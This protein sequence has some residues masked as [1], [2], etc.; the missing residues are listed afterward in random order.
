MRDVLGR[1]DCSSATS[2][3]VEHAAA[4]AH[5]K[6][7]V[8]V[9]VSTAVKGVIASTTGGTDL[10]EDRLATPLVQRP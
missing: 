2:H 5:P 6:M 8:A 7:L 3:K 10:F 9:V 4:M 1:S